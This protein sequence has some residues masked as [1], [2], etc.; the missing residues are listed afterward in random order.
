MPQDIKKKIKQAKK[1]NY[2]AKDFQSFR[3]ELLNYARTYFPDKIQDFSEAS[4]GGLLLDM[5]AMVGD[6]LS[7]YLDHQFGELNPLTAIETQNI[8]NHIRNA[9]VPIRGASPAT[10][11]CQF[12]IR[13]PY[14]LVGKGIERRP[15]ESALPILEAGTQAVS[16]SGILFNLVEDLDFS[17]KTRA[18]TLKA[19]SAID[20][21]DAAGNPTFYSL[22][23]TGVCVSGQ[24]LTETFTISSNHVPFREIVLA[25]SNVSE[26][27]SVTDSEGNVYYE[28]ESLTQDVVYGG[29]PT[30]DVNGEIVS[31][32]ME[33]IPAPYRFISIMDPVSK[34]TTLRFGSGRAD[35][36]DDDIIPDPSELALPLYGKKTFSRFVI[37]PN[38]L[39][40]TQTLGLSPI[41][42]TLSIKYR[43]GGGLNHNSSPGTIE[44]IATLITMYKL[45]PLPEI[46]QNVNSS[47]QVTNVV[48]A[49]GGLPA[50]TIDEL[51][52]AIPS[53]RQ[54]QSRIV[55]KSDMQARIYTLPS[56]YGRV[57]RSAVSPNPNSPLSSNMYVICK[58]SSDY[59]T[60]APDALKKN[61]SKYLNEYR[62][63]S[64]AIDILDAR[65][66]NFGVEFQIV[67]HPNANKRFI[68]QQV[69]E[70][71][72]RILTVK[73]FQINQ[74]IVTSDIVNIIINTDGVISLVDMPKVFSYYGSMFGR[75]YGQNSFNPSAIET[76]GFYVPPVGSIFEL[77]YPDFDIVGTSA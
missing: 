13:V 7:F 53:A 37:D 73:N 35:T 18:G 23:M 2:L 56:K 65:V 62:L 69:I 39:L 26:I 36:F 41:N 43:Y 59:L 6:N 58:D 30:Q 31:Q 45:R 44:S 68:I 1:R 9:G 60:L 72:K 48:P 10:V 42:T 25:S 52:E 51:R 71:L 54:L 50:P 40:N 66:L 21:V 27:I 76:R 5:A 63:I 4:F 14:E 74:P 24:E 19:T 46:M 57:F 61:L 11:E 12:S 75:S 64:D 20:S 77:K 33:I 49:I 38:S 70:R 67:S 34:L 3:A 32:E 16:N 17:S 22:T 15:M 28:V 29:V 55:S 47:I 8:V